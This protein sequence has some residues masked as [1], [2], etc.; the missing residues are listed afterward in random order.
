MS[1]LVSEQSG[2]SLDGYLICTDIH[3]K[4]YRSWSVYNTSWNSV[5][6]TIPSVG[7]WL[8]EGNYESNY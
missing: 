8:D 1:D 4:P 2:F 6:L 3:N 7:F 5:Y